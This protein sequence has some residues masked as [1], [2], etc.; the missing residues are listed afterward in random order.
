M[1]QAKQH[2]FTIHPPAI[3]SNNLI[4]NTSP[5]VSIPNIISNDRIRLSLLK[6]HH[7]LQNERSLT[8][9]ID[10]SHKFVPSPPASY[11]S[12]AFCLIYE[13]LN[14]EFSIAVP[15]V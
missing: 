9:Y 11:L 15:A 8:F 2:Y 3:I 1:D 7:V 13:N 10:R 5:F 4:V 14:I 12:S 6:F